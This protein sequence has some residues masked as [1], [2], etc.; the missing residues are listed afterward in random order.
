MGTR[1]RPGMVTLSQAARQLHVGLSRARSF[2]AAGRLVAAPPGTH[3]RIIWV[4][5]ES[6]VSLRRAGVGPPRP[7]GRP[8]RPAPVEDWL[9]PKQA[10]AELGVDVTT[11]ENYLKRGWLVAEQAG[12]HRRIRIRRE[13]LEAFRW[14]ALAAHAEAARRAGV[15]PAGPPPGGD[16]ARLDVRRIRGKWRRFSREAVEAARRDLRADRPPID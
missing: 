3:A 15:A 9:T 14:A 4:D 10:A 1:L 8:A 7:R 6:V 5:W 2:V 12:P 13:D 16:R 11:L